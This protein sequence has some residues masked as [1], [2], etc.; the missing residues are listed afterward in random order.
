VTTVGPYLRFGGAALEA[1][2]DAGAHYF[3]ATG[4]GPFIRRVFEE[5]GP[6]AQAAECAFLPAFGYDF[7]PGNLA[8]AL[9][10]DQAADGRI[11]TRI[12]VFYVV[13]GIG[14]SGG[15]MASSVGVML[16]PGF[17]FR[18]G[19]LTTQRQG[20]Q[21]ASFRWRGRHGAGLSIAGS[22]HLSLPRLYPDLHDVRVY[23]GVAGAQTWQLQAASAA[24]APAQFI[25]P[26]GRLI[27]TTSAV[28]WH[29]ETDPRSLSDLFTGVR[30]E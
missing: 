14:A 11:G 20:A 1:A 24:L 23:L 4:E 2:S 16:R 22:E 21:V 25:E 7:V 8:A 19:R 3:D 29:L 15:T 30:V 28:H 10:L 12:E 26:L 9:A 6:R 5:Y 18:S 17:A 27:E 13:D